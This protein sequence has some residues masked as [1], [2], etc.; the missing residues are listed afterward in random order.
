VAVALRGNYGSST[1]SLTKP[2]NLADG[3]L[4]VVVAQRNNATP[5][6]LPASGWTSVLTK[7][8]TDSSSSLRL[9]YRHVTTA[10]SEPATYTFTN[11]TAIIAVVVYNHHQTDPIF[12]SDSQ[13]IDST[14]VTLSPSGFTLNSDEFYSFALVSAAVTTGVNSTSAPTNWSHYRFQV[15]MKLARYDMPAATYSSIVY[16]YGTTAQKLVGVLFVIRP[17]ILP[18]VAT[19]TASS[20]AATITGAAKTAAPVTTATAAHLAPTAIGSALVLPP[21]PTVAA[22][23][24][25]PDVT[26]TSGLVVVEAVT[27]TGY[28][29]LLE[30]LVRLS[31]FPPTMS[32]TGELAAPSVAAGAA[33]SAELMTATATASE[34]MLG[35]M[36]VASLMSATMM[37][38]GS[39]A[40]GGALV[41]PDVSVVIASIHTPLLQLFYPVPLMSMS[42]SAFGATVL[43][44][45]VTT[46]LLGVATASAVAPK[47]GVLRTT[48]AWRGNRMSV[49][50]RVNTGSVTTRPSSSAQVT[51]NTNDA[52][53]TL[54]AGVTVS[55]SSPNGVTATQQERDE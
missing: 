22:E 5:P 32:A 50:G 45:A 27:A 23:A 7:V 40:R 42:A 34:P 43:G 47:A 4:I 3:D 28:A 37:A 2:A 20:P 17:V 13:A 16:T 10:S 9:A 53:S 41:S 26:G 25:A 36:V 44:S 55:P 18:T 21:L 52:S 11:A 29:A 15:R 12:Y 51:R 38:H 30:P 8:A 54:R 49:N 6:S 46:T 24:L 1:A 19:A 33:V 39:E 14:A 31:V 48:S 35:Q